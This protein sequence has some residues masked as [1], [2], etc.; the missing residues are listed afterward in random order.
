MAT[1]RREKKYA[2]PIRITNLV[3]MRRIRRLIPI[4]ICS[5]TAPLIRVYL[6][7]PHH[8][9]RHTHHTGPIQHF[10]CRGAAA[11][12]RIRRSINRKSVRFLTPNP[13][14]L[15]GGVFYAPSTTPPPP[16]PSSP[17]PYTFLGN[18]TRNVAILS[19]GYIASTAH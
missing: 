6:V 17:P 13:R 5:L 11:R 19:L 12:L 18:V 2:A 14:R 16:P 1:R 3:Y 7:P 15:W 4:R 8:R 9:H 10:S